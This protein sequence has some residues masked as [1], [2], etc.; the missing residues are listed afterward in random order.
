MKSLIFAQF[1]GEF[2]N[3]E[4]RTY[5]RK[6]EKYLRRK[7]HR[8]NV[9]EAVNSKVKTRILKF[10]SA[11]KGKEF[12]ITEITN[13]SKISKSRAYEILRE[14][15][16]KGIL[17]SKRFGKS[18]VYSLN[19]ANENTKN[20]LLFIEKSEEK[21]KTMLEE[22]L[23]ECKKRFGKDLISIILFGSYARG[24][25][26]ETSDIDLLVV[27]KKLPKEWL[28]RKKK[29]EE[30]EEKIEKKYE[31]NLE[32]LPLT[33]EE[34]LENL[35]DFSPLFLTFPLGY[36]VIYDDGTFVSNFKLFLERL[37]TENFV[38]YEGGKKWEIRKLVEKSL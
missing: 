16:E 34:L 36:R 22:F 17:K 35:E 10:F 11:N 32:I 12:T 3:S 31:N 19:L 15:E 33:K 29:F 5:V 13:F 9:L 8:I 25:Y 21:I 23:E 38:Y 6:I 27:I 18:V 28:E 4:N 37:K 30:I 26:K 2:F 14:L 1:V 20:V 24:T 7:N